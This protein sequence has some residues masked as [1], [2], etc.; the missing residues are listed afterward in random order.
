MDMDTLQMGNDMMTTQ[1]ACHKPFMVK[2]PDKREWQKG[3]KPDN[4]CGLVN[5]NK[6]TCVEVYR[7]GF[8]RGHSFSLRLHATIFQAE[9]HA[10]VMVNTEKEYT[11]RKIYSPSDSQ[12]AIKV[13]DN[14][15]IYSKLAWNYH[16]PC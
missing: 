13:L 9:I 4:K 15:Q 1:Y 7:W 5:T 3:I 10:H 8:R 2:F 6:G 11:C 14:F 16:Q 12:A